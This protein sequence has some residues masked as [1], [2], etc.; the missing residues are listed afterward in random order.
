MT[1]RA[2]FKVERTSQT[3]NGTEIELS[4]V[5]SG[6]KEN[7]Q[8]FKWTPYGSVKIGV[9]SAETADRFKPGQEF[10]VDFTPA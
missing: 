3:V 6:S 9:V 7:E 2:K 5:T 1:V 8:F 10:Y 4:P